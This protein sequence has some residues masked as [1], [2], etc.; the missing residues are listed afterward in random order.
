MTAYY[1]GSRIS[2]SRASGLMEEDPSILIASN[3][4]INNEVQETVQTNPI[5]VEPIVEQQ[6]EIIEAVEEEVI[7]DASN[8]SFVIFIGS[9]T[10]SIPNNV[11]TALLENSDVGIKRA[12][13]AGKMIYSTKEIDS[14]TEATIILQRFQEKGVDQVKMLYVLDGDEIS[15]QRALKILAK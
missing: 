15:E 12:V 9:Y 8:L 6:E 14:Y 3:S 1:Q 11:A 4:I 10:N 5:L 7:G 2:L 13:N